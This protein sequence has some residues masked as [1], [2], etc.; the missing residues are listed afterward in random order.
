[1]GTEKHRPRIQGKVRA[2]VGIFRTKK[3]KEELM[4][5]FVPRL[6][7]GIF[8]QSF[9]SDKDLISHMHYGLTDS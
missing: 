9:A 7:M 5:V 4:F 8:P 6:S 2:T 3:W 1:M